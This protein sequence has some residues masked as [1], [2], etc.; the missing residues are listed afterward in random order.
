MA[1]NIAFDDGNIREMEH[2]FLEGSEE[3]LAAVYSVYWQEQK[4]ILA[5]E[6][7]GTFYRKS[8]K[9]SFYTKWY[10]HLN[11]TREEY[12]KIAM[13]MWYWR[14]RVEELITTEYPMTKYC[15]DIRGNSLMLVQTFKEGEEKENPYL[16]DLAIA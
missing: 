11:Y 14:D 8:E 12:Q 10:S 3:F 6:V 9:D 15:L 1:R 4:T 2:V 16:I 7:D 5:V 13:Q